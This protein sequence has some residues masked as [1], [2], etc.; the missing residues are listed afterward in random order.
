MLYIVEKWNNGSGI[1]SNIL[2]FYTYSVTQ[3]DHQTC[4]S[5]TLFAQVHS[6]LS[7]S[8]LDW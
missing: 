4:Y 2:K 5:S 1:E 7:D 6:W 3:Q 8:S